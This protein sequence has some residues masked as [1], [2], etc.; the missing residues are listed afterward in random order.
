MKLLNKDKWLQKVLLNNIINNSLTNRDNFRNATQ[1]GQSVYADAE[2]RPQGQIYGKDIRG[3][4][5]LFANGG[6][7]IKEIGGQGESKCGD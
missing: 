3:G 4:N 5:A 7:S 2:N 1:F 6:M